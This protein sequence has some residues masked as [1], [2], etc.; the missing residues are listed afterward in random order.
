MIRDEIR[1]GIEELSDNEL[2]K[3]ISDHGYFHSD[4]EK[5]SVIREEFEEAQ[6]EA[7]AMERDFYFLWERIK[8]NEP[9]TKELDSLRLHALNCACECIQVIAMCNKGIE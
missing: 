2:R 9:Y 5:E 7:N 6:D 4:H 1:Q 3:A 8:K